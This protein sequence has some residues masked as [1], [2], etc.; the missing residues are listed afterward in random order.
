MNC[1]ATL[2]WIS[3]LVIAL[4]A[5]PV[6]VEARTWRITS[7]G[8]GDAPTIQ[9][10]VDS[11]M[12]GDEVVLTNGTYTGIGNRYITFHG[13]AITVRSE[14][15]DPSGCIIEGGRWQRG[16][17]FTNGEGPGSVVE[18]LTIWGFNPDAPGAAIFCSSSSPTIRNCL[19]TYNRSEGTDFTVSG[20]G[21]IYCYRSSPVVD[22]CVFDNDSVTGLPT[23][24]LGNE[25]A[26]ST[27]SAPTV[28]NCQFVGSSYAGT[29]VWLWDHSNMAIKN[30][31]FADNHNTAVSVDAYSSVTIERS[32]FAFNSYG[33]VCAQTGTATITCTDM[34]G[35]WDVSRGRDTDWWSACE[36]PQLG[37]NGN[38]SA[39]PLFCNPTGDRYG[40]YRLHMDSPCGFGYH[41][42]GDNCG[43]VGALTW[44]CAPA[45]VEQATWTRVKLIYK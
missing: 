21:A 27:Y 28:Q 12:T 32:L 23:C 2:P 3:C 36:R 29:Q 8:T 15:Q 14:S 13:K 41:P 33:V 31:T 7:D 30:C 22:R 17:E 10:G 25:I 18:G 6:H 44:G 40:D 43:F 37:I 9:A 4:I 24:C 20:G 11:S 34:F 16:F 19:F 38:F 26:C 39:D 42:R 45:A 35:N 5:Q 1:S